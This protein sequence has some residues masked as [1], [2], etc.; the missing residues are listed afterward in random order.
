MV[1][2]GE[3]R[4][5]VIYPSYETKPGEARAFQISTFCLRLE[6]RS[7]A[8]NSGLQGFRYITRSV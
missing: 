6:Y 4:T 8:V 3:L 1:V 7:R 5:R 2:A